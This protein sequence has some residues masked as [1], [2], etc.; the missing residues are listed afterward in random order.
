MGEVKRSIPY[1]LVHCA[2]H[3]GDPLPGYVVCT[4]A[5]NDL[6]VKLARPTRAT[7]TDMGTVVCVE[8]AALPDAP[9]EKLVTVCAH[10][11]LELFGVP[12]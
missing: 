2:G 11:V 10:A 7:N 3:P 8:C 9:V 6:R 12:L 4:H 1:P 5:L